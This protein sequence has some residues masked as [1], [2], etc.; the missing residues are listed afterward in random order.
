MQ[1]EL[2]A[3]QVARSAGEHQVLLVEL[4][5]DPT[6]ALPKVPVEPRVGSLAAQLRAGAL[7]GRPERSA[8]MTMASRAREELPAA[9][10]LRSAWA[11]AV[12]GLGLVPSDQAAS[13]APHDRSAA[14]GSARAHL[15]RAML[16]VHVSGGSSKAPC[17]CAE[18]EASEL[19][20]CPM[21]RC[22][23]RCRPP[24]PCPGV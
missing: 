16:L 9:A 14:M 11:A 15:Q 8:A 13:S 12:V 6:A 18:A 23:C 19:E 10:S 3:Q 22:R 24:G 20:Q 7:L 1:L 17:Q 4:A 2:Q 5:L 21:G